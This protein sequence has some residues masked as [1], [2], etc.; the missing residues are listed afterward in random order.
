MRE[1]L[2]QVRARLGS[3]AVIV[4]T[5]A[6]SDDGSRGGITVLAVPGRGGTVP[7]APLHSADPGTSDSVADLRAQVRACRTMLSALLPDHLRSASTNGDPQARVRIAASVP[8][9]GGID[10]GRVPAVVALVGPTGGGKTTTVARLAAT[11][12]VAEQRCTR[13][14][15]GDTH[16][17]QA[18]EMLQACCAVL[19]L[20][21]ETAR[22]PDEAAA[23]VAGGGADLILLD[24][25][26]IS[27]R[28]HAALRELAEWL[29]A[30]QPTEVDLVLPA[31]ASRTAMETAIEAFGRLSADRIILSK[32]DELADIADAL[33]AVIASGKPLSYVTAAPGAADG[34][35]VADTELLARLM[36]AEE[37]DHA[38]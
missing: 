33:T 18:A 38:R 28:D 9:A 2:D 1:A 14:I 24:T 32:V 11:V 16:R 26:G 12:G 20:A 34:L 7:A 30:A 23:A 6:R 25:P 15:T 3:D 5:R 10:L 22:T 31:T 4:E 29:A 17:A 19:G 37:G 36:A 8:L 35:R 13:V 21:V 27:P